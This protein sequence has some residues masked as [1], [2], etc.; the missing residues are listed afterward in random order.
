MWIKIKKLTDLKKYN[1]IPNIYNIFYGNNI[2]IK[3]A[4]WYSKYKYLLDF[5]NINIINIF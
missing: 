2:F 1:I 3:C 4:S 5:S